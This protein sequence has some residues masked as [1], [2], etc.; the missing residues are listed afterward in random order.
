MNAG[1]HIINKGGIFIN[2]IK[3]LSAATKPNRGIEKRITIALTLAQ[4]KDKTKE[5]QLSNPV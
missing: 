5:T 1:V 3:E 2:R 4:W